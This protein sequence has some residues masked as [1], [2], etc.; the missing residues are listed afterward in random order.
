MYIHLLLDQVPKQKVK[1]RWG[2]SK[3]E[4]ENG[5]KIALPGTEERTTAG[6]RWGR[7]RTPGEELPVRLR[8]LLLM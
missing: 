3:D 4:N 6:P 2:W 1:K 8:P 5:Q 7:R